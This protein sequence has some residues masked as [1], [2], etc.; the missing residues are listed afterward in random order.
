MPSII[1]E[2]PALFSKPYIKYLNNHEKNNIHKLLWVKLKHTKPVEY[3]ELRRRFHGENREILEY[4][5][6]VDTSLAEIADLGAI[7]L[8]FKSQIDFLCKPKF[9]ELL[10]KLFD[11]TN[12]FIDTF[13]AGFVEFEKIISASNAQRAEPAAWRKVFMSALGVGLSAF[14]LSPLMGI[15]S[16]WIE[17]VTKTQGLSSFG[18]NFKTVEIVDKDGNKQSVLSSEMVTK[19]GGDNISEA[20]QAEWRQ[21]TADVIKTTAN[22]AISTIKDSF[23][24]AISGQQKAIPSN[25]NSQF[26]ISSFLINLRG[27]MNQIRNEAKKLYQSKLDAISNEKF[28]A[29]AVVQYLMA[30][31][32]KKNL[33]DTDFHNILLTM[34]NFFRIVAQDITFGLEELFSSIPTKVDQRTIEIIILA[35]YLDTNHLN[36]I[37]NIKLN[38]GARNLRKGWIAPRYSKDL[39]WNE[40]KA[41]LGETLRNYLLRLGVAQTRKYGVWADTESNRNERKKEVAGMLAGLKEKNNGVVMLG[42]SKSQL[43]DMADVVLWAINYDWLRALH[44]AMGIQQLQE[45]RKRTTAKRHCTQCS[46]TSRP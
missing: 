38:G 28:V 7:C 32:Y 14:G 31:E 41:E 46:S 42:K 26:E 43:Q 12:C 3:E 44:E 35:R 30:L 11:Y 8:S 4:A 45:S 13:S 22:S 36:F 17:E 19:Y 37:G 18:A 33:R 39:D 2:A 34:S 24:E 16:G 23:F 6:K 15:F 10:D 5:T 27:S 9:D 20:W 40:A 25:S 21:G 1:H 29:R